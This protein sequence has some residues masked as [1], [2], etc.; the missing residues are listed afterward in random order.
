MQYVTL[1][2]R[3]SK[4][5]EGVWDGKRHKIV[6]GKNSFP[7][8]MARKFRQQHPIMGT[9]DPVSLERQYLLGIEE[10]G[11]DCSPIEQSTAE[12]LID[13]SKFREQFPEAEV[14]KTSAGGLYAH[15]RNSN[16]GEASSFVK[17]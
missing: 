9:E 5:L 14:L 10:D 6:P 8:A 11:D 12:T 4:T 17:P 15:E 16:I 3:S 2:N 13:M 1:I 7:E